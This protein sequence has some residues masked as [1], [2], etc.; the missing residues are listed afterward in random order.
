MKISGAVLALAMGCRAALEPTPARSMA[1]LES[2]LEA[3]RVRYHI[4]GLSAAIA[5]DQSVAWTRGFGLADIASN[6]SIVDT[7]VFQLASLQK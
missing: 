3:L 2:Q 1:E 4:A 5:K 6:R 7:T